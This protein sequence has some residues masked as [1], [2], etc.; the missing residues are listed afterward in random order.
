MTTISQPWGFLSGIRHLMTYGI[1]PRI[2]LSPH[3]LPSSSNGQNPAD[4]GTF[5][6]Y[7]ITT[8]V[9]APLHLSGTDGVSCSITG[10]IILT[11]RACQRPKSVEFICEQLCFILHL[12]LV[13][14]TSRSR[15]SSLDI[16]M[17]GMRADLGLVTEDDHLYHQWMAINSLQS[18]LWR[19]L[20]DED[21]MTLI[22]GNKVRQHHFERR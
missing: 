10:T 14:S 5:T 1:A 21:R 15:Y 22:D 13:Y 8:T 11:P 4:N 3:W 12:G 6:P 17:S 18:W 20:D 16:L 9:S 19:A 7:L 2:M